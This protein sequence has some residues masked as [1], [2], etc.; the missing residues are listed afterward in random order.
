VPWL[1]KNWIVVRNP[2]SPF[3]NRLFPNPYVHV[4]FEE[5]YRILMSRYSI[6]NRWTLPLEVTIRGNKT[7]GL[8]GATFLLAPIALAALR[9]RAGRRALAFALLLFPTYFGNVGTRFLMP[10][11]P[12]VALAM[13]LAFGNARV[14]LIAMMLIHA[15]LSWPAGIRRYEAKY[16]WRLDRIPWKEAL[17]IIPQD[18]YLRTRHPLYT[19]ARMLDE[20]T[21]GGSRILALNGVPESY[22][23]REILVPYQAALNEVLRDL[24]QSGWCEDFQPRRSL[25]FRFPQRALRKVRAVQTATGVFHDQYSVHEMRILRGGSELPRLPDWRLTAKPNPWDVQMAFDNSAATRWRSWE[26][27]RPG[28]FVEVDFGR[29]ETIDEVRIETSRDNQR[30]ALR[31]EGMDAE[32]RWTTLSESA[33][34]KAL[35]P[36]EGIRR[37]I[38]LEIKER[39]VDYIMLND[40]E[41][42]WDD[43]AEDPE[44]WGMREVGYA[45]GARLYEILPLAGKK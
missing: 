29:A 19:Q 1:I 4:L 7:T 39:G 6:E 23:S 34:E 30:L 44:A 28:M 25:Q 9:F 22:T 20:K 21:R 3:A 38:S 17:R 15:P 37:M 32:G 11:L 27:M 16:A 35:A 10:C 33:D 2:V 45:H 42:G 36:P 43:L 26:S 40:G 8:L 31:I 14:P 5:E 13:A 18:E 24:L 12:F 41:W